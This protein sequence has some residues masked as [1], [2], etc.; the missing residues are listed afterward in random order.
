MQSFFKNQRFHGD[1]GFFVNDVV[2]SPILFVFFLRVDFTLEDWRIWMHP[3]ASEA[4]R[5]IFAP[6]ID[7]PPVHASIRSIF[8]PS[9]YPKPIF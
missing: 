4:Q 7:P 5:R 6:S 1:V 3:I 8:Q 2:L 9:I